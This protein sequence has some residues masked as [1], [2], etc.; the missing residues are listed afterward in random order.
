MEGRAGGRMKGIERVRVGRAD[1]EQ[2]SDE[3]RANND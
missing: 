3:G 2:R 1:Q